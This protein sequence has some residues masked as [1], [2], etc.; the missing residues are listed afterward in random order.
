[1]LEL[2]GSRQ[3]FSPLKVE[4]TKLI[5]KLGEKDQEFSLTDSKVYTAFTNRL[6]RRLKIRNAALFLAL[7]TGNF[8]ILEEDGIKYGSPTLK[9]MVPDMIT[10]YLAEQLRT[11][12]EK[13]KAELEEKYSSLSFYQNAQQ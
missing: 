11:A 7:D 9:A 3:L 12:D 1:M 10:S 8:A 13:T 4:G 2:P 5:G 6:N